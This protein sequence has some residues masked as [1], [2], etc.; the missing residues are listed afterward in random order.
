[1]SITVSY[2][3]GSIWIRQDW[4][5]QSSSRIVSSNK[6]YFE[7]IPQ[8]NIYIIYVQFDLYIIFSVIVSYVFLEHSRLTLAKGNVQ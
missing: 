5:A 6:H 7:V 1:M 3:H 8:C 4:F 2:V